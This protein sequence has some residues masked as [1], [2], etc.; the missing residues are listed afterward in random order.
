MRLDR[1]RGAAAAPPMDGRL[2][3]MPATHCT[4][5]NEQR[6]PAAAANQAGAPT[7]PMATVMMATEVKSGESTGGCGGSP[8]SSL[9][10]LPV[11]ASSS[12][13]PNE[14]IEDE[15]HSVQNDLAS[16]V[17]ARAPG[18]IASIGWAVW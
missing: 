8:L 2:D 13:S 9:M 1:S 18:Q 3:F 17:G 7:H 4:P 16:T 15:L 14:T 10:A 12:N 6:L 11:L 5:L